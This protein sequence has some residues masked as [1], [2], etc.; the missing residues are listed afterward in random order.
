VEYVADF[1]DPQSRTIKAR[2]SVANPGRRLKAEMF[3]TADVTIA[4]SKAL[5][6]PATALYLQGAKYYGFVEQSPGVF[7]RKEFKAEEATLGFMRVLSG[8]KVGEKVVADG[9]LLLQQMLNVK[10]TAPKVS[11]VDAGGKWC[12]A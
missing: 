3:V 1:I 12:W 6:V 4:P 11:T 7:V 2:A 9:A 10:A 5:L 8:G